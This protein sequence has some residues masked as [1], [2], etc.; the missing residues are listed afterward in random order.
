VISSN[1]DISGDRFPDLADGDAILQPVEVHAGDSVVDINGAVIPLSAGVRVFPSG[2]NRAECSTTY[3]GSS[4]ITM[5]RLAVTFKLL[6]GIR[7]SDGAPLTVA[8]SV[9]AYH[10]AA[11]PDTPAV[12]DL[13]DRVARTASYVASDE[14]STRWT[15]LPGFLDQSYFLNFWIPLPEHIWGGFTARELSEEEASSVRPLGWGPYAIQTWK[16]GESIQL[17]KNPYYFR[18]SEGLPRFDTLIYRFV[19]E[20]ARNSLD[21]L[22][23]GGCDLLSQEIDLTGSMDYLL[24]LESEGK[25]KVEFAPD[26]VQEFVAFALEPGKGWQGFSATGAFQDARLRQAVA[27]C[28]DRQRVLNQVF[29]GKVPV[30]DTYLPSQHP[31]YNSDAAHYA[32]DPQAGSALLWAIGWVDHDGDPATPRVYRGHDPHI[33][34]EQPLEFNYW[35]TAYLGHPKTAQI[36]ADSLAQCGIQVNVGVK[37]AQE[38]FSTGPDGLLSGRRFDAAQ[39]AWPVGARPPCE[40]LLG[41]QIPGDPV[42]VDTSGQPLYPHGWSGSNITGYRDPAYEQ[43]CKAALAALP[44]QPGYLK[45][46]LETQEVFASDLPMIPLYSRLKVAATRPDMC[47]FDLDSTTKSDMWNIEAFDYGPGCP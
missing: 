39:F 7:W 18:G 25:I 37:S 2:C 17:R 12:G 3:D 21:L 16:F 43:A 38:L 5:D 29:S 26:P 30:L 4:A 35:I 11:D 36:L 27:L 31:L 14:L 8:D 15:G 1:P 45:N 44:G 46:Y 40:I 47:G 6:P 13:K 34:Q 24:Q 19:P 32:F 41:D 23:S 22:L 28:M 10:L 42:L 20:D 9:Y 33:P